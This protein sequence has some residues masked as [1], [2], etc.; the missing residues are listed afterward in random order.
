MTLGVIR[1]GIELRN[2]FTVEEF[3]FIRSNLNRYKY[4]TVNTSNLNDF[5]VY[6]EDFTLEVNNISHVIFNIETDQFLNLEDFKTKLFKIKD[7]M[8]DKFYLYKALEN[9]FSDVKIQ[10]KKVKV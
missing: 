2:F 4:K 1:Q 5:Y 9:S 3:Q 7:I 10:Q 8:L 6:G